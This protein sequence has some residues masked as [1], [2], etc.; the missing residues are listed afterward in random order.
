MSTL[1]KSLIITANGE[2]ATYVRQDTTVKE[3]PPVIRD[4]IFYSQRDPRWASFEYDSGYTMGKSGCLITCIAMIGSMIYGEECTPLEVAKR[5]GEKGAFT[6][7]LLVRPELIG[8]CWKRLTYA[9]GI[10]WYYVPADLHELKV[11]LENFDATVIQ[12][13]AHPA[14]DVRIEEN[15]HF[16]V[17]KRLLEYDAIIA[18]PWDGQEK[19]LLESEYAL[20]EW[21]LQRTIYGMRRFRIITDD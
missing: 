13:L 1:P 2:T 21:S 15:S 16:V 11:E 12:V 18:D 14:R 10:N 8:Q 20:S 5:L 9:G 7:G 19:Q 6:K 3:T 4:M 17:L